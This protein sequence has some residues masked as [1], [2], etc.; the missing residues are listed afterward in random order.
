MLSTLQATKPAHTPASSPHDAHAWSLLDLLAVA[1][2]ALVATVPRTANLLGLDPFVDEAS[3]TDWALRLLEPGSPRTWLIPVLTDGRPPLFVWTIA[4]FGALVDNGIVAGRLAASLAGVLSAIAL[5]GLGREIASRTL[6]LCAALLWALS[7]FTVFF[8]RIAADDPLLTLLAILTA[9][10]S[11][12]LARQPT[13]TTGAPSTGSG[14]AGGGAKQNP[15]QGGGR[16]APP[17]R[18]FSR[19]QLTTRAPLSA[20]AQ[21]GQWVTPSSGS[22]AA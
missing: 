22:A 14:S 21:L 4:P 2:L 3:W 1:V 5:Y 15:T 18:A 13:T 6:G 20:S 16:P 10:A 9:W 8:S 19:N 7:P 12:R 11:V 17:R